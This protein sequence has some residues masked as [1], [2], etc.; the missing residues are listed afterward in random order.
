MSSEKSRLLNSIAVFL[1]CGLS[2]IVY[3]DKLSKSELAKFRDVL[4]RAVNKS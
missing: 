3:L 4:R 1:N 2:E